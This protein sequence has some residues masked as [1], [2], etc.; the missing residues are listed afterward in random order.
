MAKPKHSVLP[1]QILIEGTVSADFIRCSLLERWSVVEWREPT[2]ADWLLFDLHVVRLEWTWIFQVRLPNFDLNS[3]YFSWRTIPMSRNESG[4]FSTDYARCF[5]SVY[6][7]IVVSSF[8]LQTSDWDLTHFILFYSKD[9]SVSMFVSHAERQVRGEVWRDFLRFFVHHYLKAE[10]IDFRFR[11]GT[12]DSVVTLV[13]HR[14]V[15]LDRVRVNN[16]WSNLPPIW[17]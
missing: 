9:G 1:R 7:T 4:V 6:F 10:K 3:D 11:K 14:N 2:F 17:F 8:L 5:S 13:E 15:C 12:G 16:D